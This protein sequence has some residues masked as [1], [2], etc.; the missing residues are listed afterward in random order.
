MRG[1]V[2]PFLG[3]TP[4]LRRH[5][6][7][8]RALCAL[9]SH[10]SVPKYTLVLSTVF[11]RK[12]HARGFE[13]HFAFCRPAA[14]PRA[15]GRSQR[16]PVCKPCEC[17]PHMA[18]LAFRLPCCMLDFSTSKAPKREQNSPKKD[19]TKRAS[20]GRMRK[21][22]KVFLL[23]CKIGLTSAYNYDIIFHANRKRNA[24]TGRNAGV[25]E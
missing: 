22:A 10:V 11:C 8:V 3:S 17:K 6:R 1:P 14:L 21:K 2:L 9:S 4:A 23:F 18:D 7:L 12:S 24:P 16:Y 19:S 15:F 20:G 13:R 5:C 25:A